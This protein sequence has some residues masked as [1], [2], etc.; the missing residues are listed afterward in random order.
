ML[1][2]SM[3]RAP[4]L[5]ENLLVLTSA[6]KIGCSDR[7]EVV[8]ELIVAHLTRV[9]LKQIEVIVLLVVWAEWNL[10]ALREVMGL[11]P[12]FFDL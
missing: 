7:P 2:L 11:F 4:D 6:N 8:F 3:G 5:T 9:V 12:N 1:S 10:F